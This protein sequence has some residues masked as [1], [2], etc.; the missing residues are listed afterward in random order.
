MVQVQHVGLA[1]G[2]GGPGQRPEG[3]RHVINGHQIQLHLQLWCHAQGEAAPHQTVQKIVVVPGPSLRVAGDQGRA[4]DPH[5]QAQPC[6]LP[7]QPFAHPLGLGVAQVNALPLGQVA[8]LVEG[9]ASIGGGL[10]N[11]RAGDV[12][13]RDALLSRQPQHLHGAAHIGAA[14]LAVGGHV[15]ELGPVMQHTSHL[16]GQPLPGGLIK[17][18]TRLGQVAGHGHQPRLPAVLPEVVVLQVASQPLARLL[19]AGGPDQAVHQQLRVPLQ[20]IRQQEGPQKPRSPR[21]QDLLWYTRH[22]SAWN[23]K[24]CGQQALHQIRWQECLI[25]QVDAPADSGLGIADQ[26]QKMGGQAADRGVPR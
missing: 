11:R 19:S 7:H 24:G 9:L 17:P 10:E 25:C 22:D 6:G 5:R 18:Q 4:V 8:G 1:A 26:V 14:Q 16:A 13:H 23:L 20:L 21:E 3:L 15:A 2:R 12:F